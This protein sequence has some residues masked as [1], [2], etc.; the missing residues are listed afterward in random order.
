MASI[1][2]RSP[3]D[4]RPLHTVPFLAVVAGIFGAQLVVY[5]LYATFLFL[6]RML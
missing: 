4:N 6:P 5:G 2:K 1:E 3:N